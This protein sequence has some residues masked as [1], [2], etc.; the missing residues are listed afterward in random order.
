MLSAQLHLMNAHDTHIAHTQP[1]AKAHTAEHRMAHTQPVVRRRHLGLSRRPVH[2]Q[3]AREE[4]YGYNQAI[5]H[6][7]NVVVRVH[8]DVD[9][10]LKSKFDKG[11][12]ARG[13]ISQHAGSTE[14]RSDGEGLGHTA[15]TTNTKGVARASSELDKL[16]REDG[17]VSVHG[18]FSTSDK[19][20]V[21]DSTMESAAGDISV[22]I[23]DRQVPAH[24]PK[25]SE[26]E[27]HK[28]AMPLPT[29]TVKANSASTHITDLVAGSGA[30]VHDTKFDKARGA[31]AA[32]AE[33]AASEGMC[34][35][36]RVVEDCRRI[37]QMLFNQ[38][39]AKG[40]IED[41]SLDNKGCLNITE[42][43]A[44]S[45]NGAYTSVSQLSEDISKMIQMY[46]QTYAADSKP[47]RMA[48]E[49]Q[50]WARHLLE[51]RYNASLTPGRPDRQCAAAAT[52]PKHT[53]PGR[54]AA[55]VKQPSIKPAE[56]LGVVGHDHRRCA[57]AENSAPEA[58]SAPITTYSSE[59]RQL[60]EQP[61]DATCVRDRTCK[62]RVSG[63]KALAPSQPSPEDTNQDT[64]KTHANIQMN[65][66]RKGGQSDSGVANKASTG[67]GA[68]STAG[69]TVVTYPSSTHTTT[70]TNSLSAAGTAC[71][72][73]RD[74]NPLAPTRDTQLLG[75]PV[76]ADTGKPRRVTKG[77]GTTL[78]STVC[79]ASDLTDGREKPPQSKASALGEA[80]DDGGKIRRSSRLLDRASASASASASSSG[81]V[82]LSQTPTRTP[83]LSPSSVSGEFI[84]GG[85][86]SEDAG[87]S[88]TCVQPASAAELAVTDKPSTT[89]KQLKALA[90]SCATIGESG[91][92]DAPVRPKITHSRED[93][94]R[95][96]KHATYNK[97]HQRVS[98]GR[99]TLHALW[100]QLNPTCETD[101]DGIPPQERTE[102][103]D[104]LSGASNKHGA[105]GSGAS[106]GVLDASTLVSKDVGGVA[107]VQQKE[108]SATAMIGLS[109]DE[110]VLDQSWGR[111]LDS[112]GG[113]R[114]VTE[115]SQTGTR[116]PETEKAHT[117][118]GHSQQEWDELEEGDGLVA[119]EKRSVHIDGQENEQPHGSDK[120]QIKYTRQGPNKLQGSIK[121]ERSI[122]RQK[123]NKRQ[124]ETTRKEGG[125]RRGRPEHHRRGRTLKLMR[126]SNEQVKP[127]SPPIGVGM[128]S[129][130]TQYIS[131]A[132]GEANAAPQKCVGL[133]RP[134]LNE[135]P[136]SAIADTAHSPDNSQTEVAPSR[137]G[138]TDL[139]RAVLQ[140][141]LRDVETAARIEEVSHLA[142]N[143]G[144]L[145]AIPTVVQEIAQR[146]DRDTDSDHMSED[147]GS[148][149]GPGDAH[150][151][152]GSGTTDAE[153]VHAP[154]G[155]LRLTRG[156]A[157]ATGTKLRGRRERYSPKHSSNS[158]KV[159][160]STMSAEVKGS[161]GHLVESPDE[162]RCDLAQNVTSEYIDSSE[163]RANEAYLP[164]PSTD[165]TEAVV[166]CVHVDTG[167]RAGVVT[168]TQT[169]H[170][171]TT[172]TPSYGRNNSDASTP[173]TLSNERPFNYRCAA[174]RVV[175]HPISGP[176]EKVLCARSPF[177]RSHSPL[178]LNL[179]LDLESSFDRPAR[180]GAAALESGSNAHQMGTHSDSDNLMSPIP[181]YT[182][183]ATAT[184]S[185]GE[186]LHDTVP[187]E[188]DR[189]GP[190]Q[191]AK[192]VRRRLSV[193]RP[194]ACIIGSNGG[195]SNVAEGAETNA[196]TPTLALVAGG[197]HTVSDTG[198]CVGANPT[199]VSVHNSVRSQQ[200][201]SP[202]AR[203]GD[204]L[205][206]RATQPTGRL[207]MVKTMVAKTRLPEDTCATID[208]DKYAEPHTKH[209][210][211]DHEYQALCASP[212][213]CPTERICATS[214]QQPGG[215]VQRA[216]G[217]GVAG[218][219]VEIGAQQLCSETL[220]DTPSESGDQSPSHQNAEGEHQNAIDSEA[221]VAVNTAR[222][223]ADQRKSSSADGDAVR[224]GKRNRD[225]SVA[226]V[227]DNGSGRG[228]KAKGISRKPSDPSKGLARKHTSRKEKEKK[229]TRTGSETVREDESR[230][231]ESLCVFD[232]SKLSD[233]SDG[234]DRSDES[235]RSEKAQKSGKA[236]RIDHKHRGKVRGGGSSKRRAPGAISRTRGDGET[237]SSTCTTG[238]KSRSKCVHCKYNADQ[239][240]HS[241]D[242]SLKHSS[243]GHKL[244][245]SRK[246]N[247]YS[248]A[249]KRLAC[250]LGLPTGHVKQSKLSF[251][252]A[253]PSR[254]KHII[255]D[256]SA[257]SIQTLPSDSVPG[258]RDKSKIMSP[259]AVETQTTL[260]CLPTERQSAASRSR[261]PPS[262][263]SSLCTVNSACDKLLTKVS[264]PTKSR[265]RRTLMGCSL[266]RKLGST[267]SDAGHTTS[268]GK[269]SRN[270]E[271]W[272]ESTS[273]YLHTTKSDQRSR[274]CTFSKTQD[275]N[276]TATT[277]GQTSVSVL[278]DISSARV[279]P[280]PL[281]E[282]PPDS[283]AVSLS[284]ASLSRVLLAKLSHSTTSRNA[285]GK[286]STASSTQ[287]E[288]LAPS[289][290][291]TD[292]RLMRPSG[293]SG[294]VQ[295]SS[296]VTSQ[297]S[298][299]IPS[300]L[301][302]FECKAAPP[303]A[304]T[305]GKGN[306]KLNLHRKSYRTIST[307]ASTTERG[308]ALAMSSPASVTTTHTVTSAAWSAQEICSIP[309]TANSQ[310]EKGV[311]KSIP[312]PNTDPDVP[313]IPIKVT[314]Q[315]EKCIKMVRKSRRHHLLSA[316]VAVEGHKSAES[317]TVTVEGI[318]TSPVEALS[319]VREKPRVLSGSQR[320][321]ATERVATHVSR[322]EPYR[323]TGTSG[324]NQARGGGRTRQLRD[325]VKGVA[326]STTE[327]TDVISSVG[328]ASP[329][330]LDDRAVM[331]ANTE[332]SSK[333]TT[334][335]H[336][337][338][339]SP[340]STLS[341][342][343]LASA[344][345]RGRE[346][347]SGSRST[348]GKR[349]RP[350][351]STRKKTGIDITEDKAF[352]LEKL[353]LKPATETA[354]ATCSISGASKSDSRPFGQL[355]GSA[356][357]KTTRKP[358]KTREVSS[359]KDTRKKEM[360]RKTGGTG[361]LQGDHSVSGIDQAADTAS[362]SEVLGGCDTIAV[363][364][365]GGEL[366]GQVPVVG[367]KCPIVAFVAPT[368][369]GK[370][371]SP[372]PVKAAVVLVAATN[373]KSMSVPGHDAKASADHLPVWE[374]GVDEPLLPSTPAQ[375]RDRRRRRNEQLRLCKEREIKERR[376]NSWRRRAEAGMSDQPTPT[377][378]IN[379][380]G[381]SWKRD[382]ET[383]YIYD[384]GVF[385]SV[386]DPSEHMQDPD[387]DM[388][389]K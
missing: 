195:P 146:V 47:G 66:I 254:S 166:S 309:H 274:P 322:S 177:K 230:K 370:M 137:G 277:L 321:T 338:A 269:R 143:D 93:L 96:K 215:V 242:T 376:E 197:V 250:L 54:S 263:P 92:T 358:V 124:V 50:R 260:P 127:P 61:V 305:H 142:D 94:G 69:A 73:A 267:G 64:T 285:D 354:P 287:L 190:E 4:R 253:V 318:I 234:S 220:R 167:E 289:K 161:M 320:S 272:T 35:D 259:R 292:C 123:S 246:V 308:H 33:A 298:Q 111:R 237:R 168:G 56:C 319:V 41:A 178:D 29:G 163:I 311:W 365:V 174:N 222:V 357:R 344:R 88:K 132:E 323:V 243:T 80:R 342:A 375:K 373:G 126:K 232:K 217:R 201:M 18:A 2:I 109:G 211:G 8:D 363:E 360:D 112:D 226:R 345:Q 150:L 141:A 20:V 328:A 116:S 175:S 316:D 266:K 306:P 68:C 280:K 265:P 380:R 72:A 118:N 352:K 307:A 239:E 119:I 221:T 48:T 281:P 368:V 282:S 384:T 244:H 372:P 194:H 186:S 258:S 105:K 16:I 23:S 34:V 257:D 27:A 336:K 204:R 369:D 58:G 140:S 248:T 3:H 235:N 261:F 216:V 387:T 183:T 385:N 353:A 364:G 270:A 171:I 24:I 293:T 62:R 294:L 169:A 339:G 145:K 284:P 76:P 249:T 184:V 9:V 283:V 75:N 98:S 110:A 86:G 101:A 181:L 227:T 295:G 374:E 218:V 343:L 203:P 303:P 304:S 159:V 327:G 46:L 148:V 314:T 85:R 12:Y 333:M 180:E 26:K 348:S 379:R 51:T 241:L 337:T 84:S 158:T 381:I 17:A 22:I 317:T 212:Q 114:D 290:D 78:T 330:Q 371:V 15:A 297:A 133:D 134:K 79:S 335:V 251:V 37:A 291:T 91:D 38:K 120:Q 240:Q 349:R 256:I 152:P 205:L 165:T 238:C 36:N 202:P 383:Y 104:R 87:E 155:R 6:K 139:P 273:L 300:L 377:K 224:K 60:V 388:V 378:D 43:L 331:P 32:N 83:E 199:Q 228:C 95:T 236:N 356:R 55:K 247:P 362:P 13:S 156:P 57:S 334:D 136:S 125:Q 206:D 157:K 121:R 264:V 160:S 122:K 71:A 355:R 130:T 271:L 325:Q 302:E 286:A 276:T 214:S 329:S 70:Q 172:S 326:S 219:K 77:E 90:L 153:A 229:N 21:R 361:S 53:P 39:W 179:S 299:P 312:L 252:K 278:E 5:S 162:Q 99:G 198:G 189:P 128:T 144:R 367:I 131:R 213:K 82:S 49:L 301:T 351:E 382:C 44:K 386:Y 52:V 31:L 210:R 187:A 28:P 14:V 200:V 310:L 102:R 100:G 40:F 262:V 207:G 63:A 30:A 113:R 173:N 129:M 191:L 25:S 223:I 347:V 67:E 268:G 359:T 103:L 138:L 81:I 188:S 233:Q 185:C 11:K 151:G 366:A 108:V 117:R 135:E 107:V 225:G 42:I 154:R 350:R 288:T 164:S 275:T 147:I 255:T 389:N 208:T 176:A 192:S 324:C 346:L 279:D 209:V 315:P 59:L 1:T 193:R 170:H 341:G 89:L 340:P 19:V 231:G 149:L 10:N 332:Q 115:C 7:T 65:H 97:K 313:R 182:C 196:E 245:V 45:K 74:L 106:L 296:R